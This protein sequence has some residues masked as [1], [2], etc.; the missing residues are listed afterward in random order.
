MAGRFLGK[1]MRL[2]KKNRTPGLQSIWEEFGKL[3]TFTQIKE[4]QWGK[5]D[6]TFPFFFGQPRRTPSRRREKRRRGFWSRID[7]EDVS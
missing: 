1:L 4:I 3:R 5:V 6:E 7:H 2:K